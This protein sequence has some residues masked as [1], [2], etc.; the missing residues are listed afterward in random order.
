MN[1]DIL[2]GKLVQLRAINRER[3][4]ELLA[5]W[6]RDSETMRLA[7]IGPIYPYPLKQVQDWLDEVNPGVCDF[8]IETVSEGKCIGTV[9]LDEIHWA[10]GYAWAGIALGERDYMGRGY[11][12]EA[13]QLLLRFAFD[14]LNLHRVQLSAFEFN[15]RAI[16]SYEKCGFKHEGSERSSMS[17]EGQRWD[18]VNMGILQSEWRLAQEG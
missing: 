5:G 17:K 11:G 14:E 12:T 7:S 18:L 9:G 6:S 15:H 13:M 16:R 3:D 4:A 1:E 2:R 10:A 8:A